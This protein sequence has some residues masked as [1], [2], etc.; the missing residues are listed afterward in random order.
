[1]YLTFN[2]IDL[3]ELIIIT[4]YNINLLPSISESTYTNRV[5]TIDYVIVDDSEDKLIQ[6]SNALDTN[7]EYK[8]LFFNTQ[9]YF[10]NA[11]VSNTSLNHLKNGFKE[12]SIEFNIKDNFRIKKA[13]TIEDL[14]IT[15]NKA[16]VNYKGTAKT[17]PKFEIVFKND[18]SYLQILNQQRN[19]SLKLGAI[20][21]IED[22]NENIETTILDTTT[23]E[24]FKY[25]NLKLMTEDGAQQGVFEVTENG[26]SVYDYYDFTTNYYYGPAYSK[27]VDSIQNFKS[28]IYVDFSTLD[29]NN[30]KNNRLEFITND[31]I[32]DLIAGIQITSAN[33]QNINSI[34]L[35]TK[36]SE[37]TI[38][39][40]PTNLENIKE[41]IE[42]LSK[43]N[44]FRGYFEIE[45][46]G[47][48]INFRI[49]K[50]NKEGEQVEFVSESLSSPIYKNQKLKRIG[51]WMSK[52]RNN[53]VLNVM[54][55]KELNLIKYSQSNI[56]TTNLFKKDS[57]LIIDN[58]KSKVFLDSVERL[59]IIDIS[60]IFF[61]FK[62]GRNDLLILSDD[63]QIEIKTKFNEKYLF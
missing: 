28:K 20:K 37:V 51:V 50:L 11:K 43:W 7:F 54:R 30:Q 6:L 10:Y 2:N 42:Y 61:E 4:G 18:A 27:D 52:F 14:A 55:V 38:S 46:I 36:L 19:S 29:L 35:K 62:N 1:M 41:S 24:G 60:N 12:G 53:N 40:E 13:T 21:Q 16:L 45:K 9:S 5:L 3:S 32:G 34:L 48:F 44:N 58:E 31:E 15:N 57:K 22:I 17:Y 49:T 47:D 59:D 56:L 39:T 33:N 23:F 8:E 25:N 26:L 63:N